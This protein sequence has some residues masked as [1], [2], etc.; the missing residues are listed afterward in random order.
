[1][2]DQSVLITTRLEA[3]LQKETRVY[4]L[5]RGSELDSEELAGVIRRTIRPWSWRSQVDEI[6]GKI[7][8]KWPE[9]ATFKIPEGL[10]IDLTGNG[11]PIQIAQP[12]QN[13]PGASPSPESTTTTNSVKVDPEASIKAMQAM[14]SLLSSSA[15]AFVHGLITST[16]ILHYADPPQGTIESL[17][18]MLIISQSQ[19]AHREIADL[20]EQIADATAPERDVALD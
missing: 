9:G 17:P 2:Q 11:S 18:G 8:M 15:I 12:Y 7:E 4:K 16:E 1:V 19:G 20:L 14:G 5:P 13:P 10:S 3:N 6:I